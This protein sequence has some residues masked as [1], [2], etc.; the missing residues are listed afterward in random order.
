MFLDVAT[1][2]QPAALF[3][4]A[5]SRH[6]C[7]QVVGQNLIV[8]YK[9]FWSCAQQKLLQPWRQSGRSSVQYLHLAGSALRCWAFECDLN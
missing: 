9:G 6:Y 8:A 2:P 3:I 7:A 1:Q 5:N 4:V